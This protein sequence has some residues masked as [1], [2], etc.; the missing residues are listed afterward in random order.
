MESV[1]VEMP[2]TPPSQLSATDADESTETATATATNVVAATDSP[3]RE[4]EE[5]RRTIK[6]KRRLLV[7]PEY[8]FYWVWPVTFVGYMFVVAYRKSVELKDTLRYLLP[9]GWLDGVVR[10]VVPDYRGKHRLDLSDMQWRQLHAY[11]P[12]LLGG[13]AVW[14]AASNAVRALCGRTGAVRRAWY[15]AGSAALLVFLHGRWAVLP[16]AVALGNFALAR[17]CGASRAGPWVAWA[18]HVLVTVAMYATDGTLDVLGVAA[19]RNWLEAGDQSVRW[20]TVFKITM[21][22]MLSYSVD[23]NW[24]CRGTPPNPRALAKSVLERQ[25]EEHRPRAEYGLADYLVYAFYVPLYLGGPVVTYNAFAA[26]YRAPQQT[27]PLRASV[28]ALVRVAVYL[29]LF[30][31]VGHFIHMLC[32][33]ERRLWYGPMTSLEMVYDALYTLTWMYV[34]FLIMWRTFRYYAVL[35][36]INTHENMPRCIYMVNTPS[37]MWRSWHASFNRWTV[38]YLYVPLGGSRAQLWSAWLIFVY[39]GLWHGLELP[40]LAWALLNCAALFAEAA[41]SRLVARSPVWAPRTRAWYWVHVQC[42]GYTACIVALVLANLS[43]SH[44]F[45]HT[46]NFVRFTVRNPGAAWT[47][48]YVLFVLWN[49]GH[50]QQTIQQ[51]EAARARLA[52]L[53]PDPATK[54]KPV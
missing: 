35:D 47:L 18:Y 6:E 36:G 38:R 44:G 5:L 52:V 10:L 15:L 30:D 29:V 19:W 54:P 1:A 22:R 9:V 50:I 12:A 16:V 13:L 21:L 41:V 26:Q 51:I 11:M 43:I 46:F 31:L 2:Q 24:A 49:H 48:P 20:H 4:I 7:S 40:W 42:L 32:I 53:V 17:A 14:A 25:Q 8:L 34:K 3:T 37:V 45:R 23:Y 27:V 39:I 28:R 33:N